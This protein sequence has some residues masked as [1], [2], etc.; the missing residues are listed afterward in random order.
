MT[1]ARIPQAPASTNR[2]AGRTAALDAGRQAAAARRRADSEACR[3]RVLAVIAG[4]RKTRGPLSD[5]EITRR[6]AV[7]PQYLQRHQDLK[8][9]AEAV[10][11]HL[12][13]DRTRAA[14]AAAARQDA[15]LAVENRMLL[16]Q[17]TALRR[18]LEAARAE[19][20]AVR[21]RDLAADVLGDLA[22]A[23]SRNGEVEVLRRERDQALAAVRRADTELLALRNV[24]QRLM[25]ENTRLLGSEQQPSGH[26]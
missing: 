14:T 11:A 5:A 21:V 12:D 1:G 25:V 24:V 16:E 7:N 23:P 19:L 15:G 8:A 18:D 17:N 10:R 13:R 22:S 6:A 9:E 26:S 2:A 3:Q 4:M 20:R